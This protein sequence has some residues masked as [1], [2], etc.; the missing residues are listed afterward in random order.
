MYTVVPT[1]LHAQVSE[2]CLRAG[3]HVLTTKPMDVNTANCKRLIK[4]AKETGC[5]LGVDFDMRMDEVTLSLKKALDEGWFG[6]LLSAQVSLYVTRTQEYYD[7]NGAWRGTWKMDG[8]GAMCNQGIHEIDRMQYLLGM[9]K[10][11][12]P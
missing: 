3:K 1:G 10:E 4:T 8:G 2:Q 7:E 5:L 12:V 9:P 6:H 11:Y